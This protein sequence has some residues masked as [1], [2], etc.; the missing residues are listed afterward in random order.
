MKLW[1]KQKE[2]KKRLLGMAKVNISADV[3]KELLKK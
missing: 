3:F 1:K 2:G